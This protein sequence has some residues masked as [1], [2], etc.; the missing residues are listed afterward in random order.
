VF[1]AISN[2][3][4]RYGNLTTTILAALIPLST[5]HHVFS[6]LPTPGGEGQSEGA[7][8][9]HEA[10]A[11]PSPITNSSTSPSPAA[12]HE[13]Q[14]HRPNDVS[15]QFAATALLTGTDAVFAN[16]CE[17]AVSDM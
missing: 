10:T 9:H 1:C 3:L 14:S 2:S 6:P 5:R 11:E 17:R 15:E 16:W 4:W 13:Q 7:A 12:A 8:S